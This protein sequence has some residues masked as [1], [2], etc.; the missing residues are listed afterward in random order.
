MRRDLLVSISG[1]I[2]WIKKRNAQG[3]Y[4][5]P[6]PHLEALALPISVERATRRGLTQ[7][8]KR[9]TGRC[10]RIGTGNTMLHI[11]KGIYH[12]PILDRDMKFARFQDV[13]KERR[14]NAFSD[15]CIPPTFALTGPLLTACAAK[16]VILSTIRTLSLHYF[17]RLVP[18]GRLSQEPPE[19]TRTEKS[20]KATVAVQNRKT[21]SRSRRSV[22][23][24]SCSTAPS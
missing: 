1:V 18:S 20:K 15:V 9:S 3:Q 5:L 11:H 21:I 8:C 19:G 13:K 2:L 6:V 22:S 14:V 23:R 10:S 16:I 7:I 4:L 17:K 12:Y 24:T